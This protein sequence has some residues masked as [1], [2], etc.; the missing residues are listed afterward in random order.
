MAA[1]SNRCLIDEIIQHPFSRRTPEEQ[2]LLVNSAVPR[3]AME[4]LKSNYK[5]KGKVMM[6]S[7]NTSSYENK[8]LCGSSKLNKLFCWPCL[9]LH[10]MNERGVW[11]KTGYDDLNHLSTSLKTHASSKDHIN[12]AFALSTYGRIRIDEALD[13]GREVARN[14][15]NDEVTRNRNGMRTLVE[16]TCLLGSHGLAFRGHDETVDSANRGNYKDVCSLVASKDPTFRDFLDNKVF[17]GTSGGIQNEIIECVQEQ[18][19]LRIKQEVSDA[20]FV[21]VMVDESTDSARLSQLSC[22][23]RYVKPDGKLIYIFD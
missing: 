17:S 22:A 4:Q 2:M 21:S 7:F 14:R 11:S 20:E 12:N 3:P 6:R 19:M 10:N 15:H 8:W 13:H 1:N 23:L 5:L 18:M 16:T 9:L